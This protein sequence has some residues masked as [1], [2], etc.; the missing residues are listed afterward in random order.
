MR[1][2]RL[3]AHAG[4]EGDST[5]DITTYT[6][7]FLSLFNTFLAHLCLSWNTLSC[8][9]FSPSLFLSHPS[10]IVWS[11]RAAVSRGA[12]FSVSAARLFRPRCRRAI[13]PLDRSSESSAN[14]PAGASVAPRHSSQRGGAPC[15]TSTSIALPRAAPETMRE[16]IRKGC[17]TAPAG[18]ARMHGSTQ[19]QALRSLI[20]VLQHVYLRTMTH[21]LLQCLKNHVMLMVFGQIQ[22]QK[23][24]HY[25]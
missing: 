11:P 2:L 3:T 18:Y 25:R 4:R 6:L 12:P 19:R 17:Q 16:Q 9:C 13:T 21:C 1:Y 10:L 20:T 22:I 15:H 5:L 23:S 8:T 24:G 14:W 7:Q